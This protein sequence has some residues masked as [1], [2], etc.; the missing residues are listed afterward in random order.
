MARLSRNS[1]YDN[2]RD[3]RRCF[4]GGSCD[5]N[6]RRGGIVLGTP[7]PEH[8]SYV[9]PRGIGVVVK[10]ESLARI[11]PD[12]A[13]NCQPLPNGAIAPPIIDRVE[14]RGS[15][16]LV[17]GHAQGAPNARFTIEV[18]ANR[19]AGGSEGEIFLA[20][21]SAASDAGG[22]AIFSLAISVTL[23]SAVPHSFTATATSS[24]GGT[25][26]FSKPAALA[27]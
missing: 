1:I 17:E 15:E 27:E 12:G 8:A 18:F 5:P 26:E 6:L 3:V 24:E 2:G 13:P 7:G 20:D 25:S 10:P 11:C 9:G 21:A 16:V 19:Q 4:A 22:R 14:R 23:H